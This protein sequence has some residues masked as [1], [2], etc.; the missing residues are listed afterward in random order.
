MAHARILCGTC[1]ICMLVVLC[2][3]WG[4]AVAV[5]IILRAKERRARLVAELARLDAFLAMAEDLA[6]DEDL[7]RQTDRTAKGSR[8]MARRGAGAD[9]V[10]AAVE[11][12]RDCG[13][14]LPT[15]ELLPMIVNRGIEVG[16]KSPIATLSARL[17]G[18]KGVLQM[19]AGRWSL[20]EHSEALGPEA[21][22]EREESAHPLS[23]ER[24]ADSLFH[25]TKGGTYA[26]ALA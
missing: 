4:N 11:I 22:P 13:H 17:S 23:T 7:S 14:P 10:A 15:R 1:K 3:V 9:T 5:D 6:R 21:S 25:Q 16:G 12:L 8:Q 2:R 18:A 24:S 26:A 19:S 20:I